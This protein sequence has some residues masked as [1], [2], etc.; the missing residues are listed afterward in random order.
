MAKKKSET[1][2][3]TASKTATAAT[4]SRKKTAASGANRAAAKPK[5]ITEKQTKTEIVRIIAEDTGLTGKQ[6]NDVFA[7]MN[8]VIRRH[9]MRRGSGEV[10]IPDT[11]IKIRRVR[12]PATRARKGVNP[13]TGEEMTFKAKPARNSV[14]LSALKKLKDALE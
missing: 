13:F 11:G 12:K 5:A 1:T 3:A 6:V 8:G 9:M 7:S 10:T 2:K 14:R 4:T